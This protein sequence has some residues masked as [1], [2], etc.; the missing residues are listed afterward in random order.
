MAALIAAVFG[1]G[2]GPAVY[3][4]QQAQ[5]GVEQRDAHEVHHRAEMRYA[6]LGITH[7]DRHRAQRHAGPGRSH[8]QLEL[9]LVAGRQPA[10]AP[11]AGEGI[12]AQPGLRVG[13]VD[14]RLQAEPEVRETVGEGVSAGHV[15]VVERTAAD[16]QGR[17]VAARG[18]D[19]GRDVLGVV[20]SVGV[21]RHRMGEAAR[22]GLAEAFAQGIS[23]AAVPRK[24]DDRNRHR[25]RGEARG[26]R[27]GRTVVHHDDIGQLPV[28]AH[29]D[30]EERPGIVVCRDDGAETRPGH[31]SVTLP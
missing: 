19:E 18:G 17:R 27:I 13:Q 28:R 9:R 14:A 15:L 3:G 29:N 6:V 5:H 2:T 8:E 1:K 26:R 25:R 22:P 20:L 11:N 21:D 10:L 4:G 16:D 24:G 30:V 23:L 12:D 7:P 31:A